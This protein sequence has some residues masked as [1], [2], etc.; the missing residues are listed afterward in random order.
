MQSNNSNLR[1]HLT[2][3]N[4]ESKSVLNNESED[5]AEIRNNKRSRNAND[6]EAKEKHKKSKTVPDAD[7]ITGESKTTPDIY[8]SLIIFRFLCCVQYMKFHC[9]QC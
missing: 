9:Q 5:Q 3:D 6:N 2:I 4:H 7:E 1:I 8:L